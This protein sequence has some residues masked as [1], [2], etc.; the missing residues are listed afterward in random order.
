MMSTPS[1]ATGNTSN[2]AIATSSSSMNPNESIIRIVQN[3]NVG[4]SNFLAPNRITNN[5]KVVKQCKHRNVSA[6]FYNAIGAL[7]NLGVTRLKAGRLDDAIVCFETANLS[8]QQVE[9]IVESTG[10]TTIPSIPSLATCADNDIIVCELIHLLRIDVQLRTIRNRVVS[11]DQYHDSAQPTFYGTTVPKPL[12][13]SIMFADME[14]MKT[15]R[16]I[17]N[18]PNPM[19]CLPIFSPGIYVDSSE[20]TCSK[21]ELG[22]LYIITYYNAALA[23]WMKSYQI[24][25][26][27]QHLLPFSPQIYNTVRAYKLKSRELFQSLL[28]IIEVRVSRFVGGDTQFF[29]AISVSML[30]LNCLAQIAFEDNDYQSG[31]EYTVSCSNAYSI[32]KM[33]YFAA[34]SFWG[35]NLK[36]NIAG[37]A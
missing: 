18:V 10:T 29:L 8:I 31:N 28:R 26:E 14:E 16:T 27:Y 12:N 37:A 35:R 30:I 24:Q 23:L 34:E 17:S 6:R 7:N 1:F 15:I 13:V 25:K 21:D 11:A 3:R 4:S 20:L 32:L 19:E 36:R 33:W 9:K 5:T 22:F 2:A